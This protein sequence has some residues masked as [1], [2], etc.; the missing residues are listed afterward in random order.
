MKT[1][2]AVQEHAATCPTDVRFWNKADMAI[3][4]SDVRFWA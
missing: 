4:P 1:E 3:A 2:L